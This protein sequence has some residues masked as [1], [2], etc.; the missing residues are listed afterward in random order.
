MQDV[1]D[2]I[3]LAKNRGVKIRV[4]YDSR[5]TQNSMQSLIN[6]GILISKR[7]ASLDGIMHNKFFIIDARDTI[8][9][10]NWLWTGSWNVTS[11]ELNW[12]K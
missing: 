11:T 7:P 4:V 12:K 5:D 9:S 1:A 2:A 3:I 8:A 6:A 10:N